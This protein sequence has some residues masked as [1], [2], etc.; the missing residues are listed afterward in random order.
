MTFATKSLV[1][2]GA[3]GLD[4]AFGE[5]PNAV[6]PVA[7]LGRG[8]ST[9]LELAPA[10][11]RGRKLAFGALLS[12]GV[13]GVAAGAAALALRLA[14]RA[15][16]GAPVALLALKST[17]ALRALSD[18]GLELALALERGG[19][20]S[21]RSHLSS[22]CSRDP[23]PLDARQLAAAAV[24]SLAENLSD[25]VVAPLFYYALFGVPGA[26]FYRAVNTLDAMIGY[27][28]RFEHLGKASA[29]LD[30]ALNLAPAR[31]T[32]L[33]LLVAGGSLGLSV[34]RGAEA[35]VRDG[36]KTE[37]PNA[38]RPMAAAAGLLGVA[39]EKPG[40]YVLFAEGGPATPSTVREADAL[41]RLAGLLG[42]A[43]IV[44]GIEA[45]DG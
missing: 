37:S 14:G 34:R 22:L 31:I 8:V 20:K 30:D 5:P 35:L 45:L 44:A 43:L 13:P 10:R 9:L 15:R 41:V 29:R 24:E 32:A 38:G 40:H 26:V 12:V 33:L 18:A 23:E 36:A 25:S 7:Q 1:L 39:L 6:H 27:R 28:G 42:A 11:G 4:A 17:F 19:A 2:V 21:A 16:M 3:L